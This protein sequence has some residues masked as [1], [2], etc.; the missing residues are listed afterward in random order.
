MKEAL[1]K[2]GASTLNVYL[3]ELGGGLL[4][5]ATFPSEYTSNP[6]DDGVVILTGTLPG[7]TKEPFNLGRTLTH[8]V[9]HWVGLY[10]TFQDGCDSSGDLVS[11][12]PSEEQP[13]YGCPTNTPDSC[14]EDAGVDPIHNVRDYQSNFQFMDYTD[15]NCMFEFSRGQINRF[16][17]QLLAFRN[18]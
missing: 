14:L 2:G 13:Q 4:G 12:T 6:L 1:R 17:E 18:D 10:H 5:Y 15:D 7:G 3:A 16:S 9:G 8:E 11:D